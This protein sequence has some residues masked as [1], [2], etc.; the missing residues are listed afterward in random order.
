MRLFL[1]SLAGFA[2]IVVGIVACSGKSTDFNDGDGSAG[3]G[4][5]SG[6]TAG[7]SAGGSGGNTTGGNTTGGAATGGSTTGG[8]ATGGNTT[9]GSTTGGSATG[10]NAGMAPNGGQ[11]GSPGGAAGANMSGA[12]GTSA[13]TGAGGMANGGERECETA[14][15]C[16]RFTDCCRCEA[17]PV[18]AMTP[19]CERACTEDA[20]RRAGIAPSDVTCRFGRCVLN[21]SCDHTEA[22]CATPPE[23]CPAGQIRSL[24][25][26]DCWGECLAVTECREV[27]DCSSCGDNVCVTS[28]AQ[29][30]YHA[31][32]TP[33]PG[34]TKG[35]YC[36]CLGAC[37]MN[38]FE[39]LEADD[40][41]VCPC[42]VC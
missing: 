4:G 6:G 38:G 37:A 27:T 42:P 22:M 12:A 41:V 30:P 32:V 21:R 33:V 24:N 20:C 7:T 34:C 15:D 19:V 17:V 9:G 16:T 35:N 5:G 26:A 18:G 29:L 31:C 8:S 36:A 3:E 25:D 23:P 28:A 39:C 10:G 40:Q 13:G 11:A 14:D 1:A 2:A